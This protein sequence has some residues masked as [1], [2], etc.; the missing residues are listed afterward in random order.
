MKRFIF[1]CIAIVLLAIVCAEEKPEITGNVVSAYADVRAT[2]YN[3]SQFKGNLRKKTQ[4]YDPTKNALTFSYKINGGQYRFFAH[5]KNTM[6]NIEDFELSSSS[7]NV[8]IYNNNG[9]YFQCAFVNDAMKYALGKIPL[10][11]TL[12]FKHKSSRKSVEVQYLLNPFEN[13]LVCRE[14]TKKIAVALLQTPLN[15]KKLCTLL[16]VYEKKLHV[17]E[18]PLKIDASGYNGK[19][20]E[21]GYSGYN[22]ISAAMEKRSDGKYYYKGA[23]TNGG[24]GG[25]GGDGEDGT[26]GGCVYLYT[27]VADNILEDIEINVSGGKGGPGGLGGPGG[28]GGS[29]NPN[30]KPG[31]R[32]PN[33][34]AGLD[35]KDGVKVISEKEDLVSSFFEDVIHPVFNIQALKEVTENG[36]LTAAVR[37]RL[38]KKYT[39]VY[40]VSNGLAHVEKKGKHGYIDTLGTEVIPCIYKD[41]RTFSNGFAIVEKDID[42]WQY[43]DKSGKYLPIGHYDELWNFDK[44]YAKVA[45]QGKHGYIDATG[46]EVIPPKYVVMGNA[47][48]VYTWLDDSHLKQKTVW[49]VT[50]KPL[51]RKEKKKYIKYNVYGWVDDTG[52]EYTG[53]YTDLFFRIGDVIPESLWDY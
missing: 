5:N 33:G 46:K 21:Q 40:S 25:P 49:F 28:S 52:K 32:G 1:L 12:V 36:Y 42:V 29:G 37:Q 20:G 48:S 16:D 34:R 51:Y 10:T 50:D 15:N 19:R 53:E 7:P 41:A 39:K 24:N 44:G 11:G 2:F 45:I 26:N 30:G 35:G 31:R 17:Y 3:T 8:V 18:L 47:N 27:S 43:I 13:E 14:K 23:G 9:N 22:G 6:Y 4:A 38:E